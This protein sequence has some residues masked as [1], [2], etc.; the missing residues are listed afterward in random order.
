MPRPRVRV[1]GF[2]L[3][4]DGFGAGPDQ[5]KQTPLGVGGE[6]LHAWMFPTRFFHEMVKKPGGETG[7]DHDFAVSAMSNFG[8]YIMGRNMFGPIRGDWPDDAWKGWWGA[9]PPYHAPTF[10]LT[11]HPRNDLIMEGG[12]TFHFVTGGIEEALRR[13]KHAA[14]GKDVKIA[15]GVATVRQYLAIDAID[16]MHLVYSPTMLGR[17]ESLLDGIDLVKQ[18]FKVTESV[19]TPRAMHV[20]L[21]K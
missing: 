3:S 14:G 15:G 7:I 1:A 9:N 2:T 12:T 21:A 16:E 5:T 13:A 10:V 19:A 20:V 17:G 6:S 18:G 4:L 8:A 11:H